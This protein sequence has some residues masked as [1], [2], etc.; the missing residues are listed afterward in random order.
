[1]HRRDFCARAPNDQRGEE[2]GVLGA[3]AFLGEA[4]EGGHRQNE[5]QKHGHHHGKHAALS[6]ADLMRASQR[7]ALLQEHDADAD[8]GGKADK[9]HQR[10]EVAAA[11][12]QNHPQGAA[13]E[14]QCAD[15]HKSAQHEPQRRRGAGPCPK[16][17][18]GQR[19][20]KGTQHQTDDLGTDILHFGGTVKPAGAGDVPQE[21]GNAEAHVGRVP[22]QRQHNGRKAHCRAGGKNDDGFFFHKFLHS[23][24]H[25]LYHR[26][27]EP[28]ISIL[29]NR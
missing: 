4:E 22:Q 28:D 27:A 10:V 17:L 15:H 18:R 25:S 7:E 19:H 13:Q 24:L 29:D 21:A 6:L 5:N 26:L 2:S 12:T 23:L 3:G 9:S 8:T 16:L 11:Q 1:M 20:D 14:G